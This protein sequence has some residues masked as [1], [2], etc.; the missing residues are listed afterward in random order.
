MKKTFREVLEQAYEQYFDDS[1]DGIELPDG[2]ERLSFMSVEIDDDGITAKYAADVADDVRWLKVYTVYG[3]N[4]TEKMFD[5][6]V[7]ALE[8]AYP[9]SDN[10]DREYDAWRDERLG[11]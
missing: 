2:I 11:R 7:M 1:I 4:I 6:M 8:S 3:E 9:T 5:E 10:P